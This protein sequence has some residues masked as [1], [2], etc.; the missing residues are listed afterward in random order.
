MGEGDYKMHV[1]EAFELFSGVIIGGVNIAVLRLRYV[2]RCNLEKM[3][4]I[5]IVLNL[6]FV[7]SNHYPFMRYSGIEH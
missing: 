7:V 1:K 4:N 6:C 2:Y 3:S 5:P